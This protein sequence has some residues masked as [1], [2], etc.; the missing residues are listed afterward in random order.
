[1]QLCQTCCS[2]KPIFSPQQTASSKEGPINKACMCFLFHLYSQLLY[3]QN[4]TPKWVP[5]HKHK[6]QRGLGERFFFFFPIFLE[7]NW[8]VIGFNSKWK[9]GENL[10]LWVI[11]NNLYNVMLLWFVHDMQNDLCLFFFFLIMW[12]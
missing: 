8:F 9:N 5:M 4:L 1:M 3:L 6:K 7:G 10:I 12:Y 11:C 2:C